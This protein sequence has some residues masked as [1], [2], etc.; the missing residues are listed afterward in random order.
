VALARAFGIAR[1]IVP[2]ASS[3]FSAI[4]CVTADMQYA[5]QQTLRMASDDWDA[6]RLT[7]IQAR[8]VTRLAAP[9][10]AA[11]YK[12]EHINADFVA[13]I[14]YSGQSY[15]TEIVEPRLEDSKSLGQQFRD[16]HQ[17]LYGFATDEPWELFALRSTVTSPREIQ[18]DAAVAEK[19]PGNPTRIAPCWFGGAAAAD[20]SRYDR[21]GI[22]AGQHVSG[23]AVIEDSW[24]TIVVP[25]GAV[26]SA[27]DLGHL[28]IDVGEEA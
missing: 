8:L 28:H 20:T 25:P 23:P 12:A 10:H 1:V 21:N 19:G 24:S 4:G 7:Q 17:R 14:R 2:A 9:L 18:V 27:D 26:A 13:S 22:A 15:A 6:K 16:T 3:V 5:Q 11:G